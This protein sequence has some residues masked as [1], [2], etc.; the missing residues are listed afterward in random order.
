M[1][2]MIL[3]ALRQLLTEIPLITICIGCIVT[4]FIFW[5]RAPASSLYLV[6][7]C[8]FTLML[9]FMYPFAWAIVLAHGAQTVPGISTAFSVGWSIARGITLI[10]LVVAVYAGRKQS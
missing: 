2:D 3:Y 6:L 7:A 5:R 8:G 10:L 9:L 4:A 1:I